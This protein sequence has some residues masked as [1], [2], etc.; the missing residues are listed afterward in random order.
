MIGIA[1]SFTVGVVFGAAPVIAIENFIV[2]SGVVVAARWMVVSSM[3][4]VEVVL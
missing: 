2:S 1:F 4:A 3:A